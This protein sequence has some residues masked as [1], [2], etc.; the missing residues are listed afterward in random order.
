M[1]TV[2]TD[3]YSILVEIDQEYENFLWDLNER[4]EVVAEEF[5]RI[6]QRKYGY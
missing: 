4:P 2:G 1:G 3:I 5:Q 6:S